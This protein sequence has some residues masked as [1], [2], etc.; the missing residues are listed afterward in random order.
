M[1]ILV[2]GELLPDQRRS[3]DLAVLLDQAP[4]RLIGE[5]SAGNARHDERIDE[6]GDDGQRDDQHD[7]G[8]DFFQHNFPPHARCKAVTTRSIA[9][10]PMNGMMTPPTP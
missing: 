3:D 7:R 4:L 1:E 2:A 9:L 6:T 8:A 5:N 10:M